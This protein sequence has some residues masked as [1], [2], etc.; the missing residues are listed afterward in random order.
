VKRKRWPAYVVGIYDIGTFRDQVF[1]A[2][3]YVEGTSSGRYA[4][5]RC[6]STRRSVRAA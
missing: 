4:K 2:M 5:A 3:E 6:L 1:I